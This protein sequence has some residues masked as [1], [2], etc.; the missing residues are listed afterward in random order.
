MRIAFIGGGTMAEAI[1]SALL[2]QKLAG[3][4]EIVAGEI[5][6]ERRGELVDR[7]GINTTGDNKEAAKGADMVVFA[8]KPHQFPAAAADLRGH[9]TPEQTV[10]SLMAGVTIEMLSEGLRHKAIIRIM[11]NTPAQVGE[12]VSVWTAAPEAKPGVREQVRRMLAATGKEIFLEDEK[13]I[14]MAT[15]VSGS[16]AGFVFL[17]MEAFIDGAVHLGLSRDTAREMVLQTF[18]GSARIAQK[19][20][21]S[22]SE[23]RSLV[24]TPGGTTAEGLLTLEEAGVRAAI[25]EALVAAYEKSRALGGS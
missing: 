9:L 10:I 11:P 18:V 3:P 1:I 2:T 20:G 7:Y 23:L 6:A 22:T 16:G 17:L 4:D 15:S 24:T 5:H 12:G 21:K 25:I 8:V 13:F 19:T 14:D